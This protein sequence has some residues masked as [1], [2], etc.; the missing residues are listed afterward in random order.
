MI[1]IIWKSIVYLCKKN[2]KAL[3]ISLFNV[4]VIT[5]LTY[6][7]DNQS[8]LF[9]E[10]LSTFTWIELAK[11]KCKKTNTTENNNNTL[12]VNVAYDKTLIP[13][14]ETDKEIENDTLLMGE[15][16]ITDRK[17]LLKFLSILQKTNTYAYI[18]LDVRFETKY[19]VPKVDS[20]LFNK[21][22]NMR[23][24]VVANHSDMETTVGTIASK[25]A[26]NDYLTS[27]FS[28]NFVRYKFL[29]GNQ[30]S[31]ALYAY[32]ELT[33]KDICQHAFWYACDGELCYNRMFINFNIDD[34][35]NNQWKNLGSDMLEDSSEEDI[36]I[37]TKNKYIVIGDMVNDIHD[38]YAGAKSGSLITINAFLSL[39]S[40]KHIVSLWLVFIMAAIYFLISMSQFKGW[41]LIP[42]SDKRSKFLL[43]ACSF[44][45]YT[46]LLIMVVFVLG[47]FGNMYIS[48]FVPSLY[49]SIQKNIVKYQNLEQ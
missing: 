39:M 47:Y 22:A 44:I 26:M 19:K 14:Y 46:I 15:D 31:M 18:F 37:V 42:L 17:K 23:N 9:G 20:L 12:F 1:K 13:V 8:R 11:H 43:F 2:S 33:G 38:T 32:R 40:G 34:L 41:S 7:L 29:Y 21:I 4:I 30:P 5:L 48:V 36:A 3:M 28:T 35:S 6:V 45:E 25:L 10:D 16:A 27:L 49:F 24:I